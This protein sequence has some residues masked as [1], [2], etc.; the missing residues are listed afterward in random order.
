MLLAS[1]LGRPVYAR[2]GYWPLL[3]FT[4]WAGHRRQ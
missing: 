4:F 1:D 3:R 2:L